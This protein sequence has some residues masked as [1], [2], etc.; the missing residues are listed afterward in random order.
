MNEQYLVRMNKYI[1]SPFLQFYDE[2]FAEA[3]LVT[4]ALVEVSLVKNKS[5]GFY[6]P[7]VDVYILYTCS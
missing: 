6:D 4:K 3:V 2:Y 7:E 5:F 1:V